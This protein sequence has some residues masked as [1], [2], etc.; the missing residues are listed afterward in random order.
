MNNKE[1][2]TYPFRMLIDHGL[3]HEQCLNHH[4]DLRLGTAEILGNPVD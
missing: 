4:A 3:F 2:T 1:L